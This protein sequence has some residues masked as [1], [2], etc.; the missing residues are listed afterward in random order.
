MTIGDI[1]NIIDP[2]NTVLITQG[3]VVTMVF[4]KKEQ[5]PLHLKDC[6]VEKISAGQS[7]LFGLY[8]SI[9]LVY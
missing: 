5:M 7:D 2:T 6:Y 8:I 1:Y 9:E 4:E 3:D